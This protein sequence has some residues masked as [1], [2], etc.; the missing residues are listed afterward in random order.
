MAEAYLAQ[1]F[2]I[3]GLARQN[4]RQFLL[5][6]QGDL[7][8]LRQLTSEKGAIGDIHDLVERLN[9]R[10]SSILAVRQKFGDTSVFP[11]GLGQSVAQ[12]L[13]STICSS[14]VLTDA[15][16]LN[17]YTLN[18]G[19][20]SILEL[21]GG[22][23]F[24]A[25]VLSAYG[26][27]VHCTDRYPV[28]LATRDCPEAVLAGCNNEEERQMALASML[29]A[30]VEGREARGFFPVE[31]IDAVD[32]V[33]RYAGKKT[34]LFMCFPPTVEGT[35]EHAIQAF[36]EKGGVWIVMVGSELDGTPCRKA[37]NALHTMYEPVRYA[38]TFWELVPIMP[39]LIWTPPHADVPIT[40]IF[41]RRK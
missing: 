34:I 38:E 7:N 41:K 27:K 32:A 6:L 22:T 26:F 1:I 20:G 33:R 12:I 37:W 16:M 13:M 25:A 23:G 39:C 9:D 14:A 29:K 17:L 5:E 8:A 28:R 36:Y 40:M 10:L 11:E 35:V 19:Q 24:N 18:P 15:Q 4:P 30:K 21:Y 2:A 31:Q 3:S